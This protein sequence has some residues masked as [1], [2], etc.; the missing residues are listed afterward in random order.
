[1]FLLEQTFRALWGAEGSDVTVLKNN[2][3]RIMCL[4]Q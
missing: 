2:N 1:M 3:I 4:V